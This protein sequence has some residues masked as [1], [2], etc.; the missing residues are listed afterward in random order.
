MRVLMTGGGTAGHVNPAIAIANTIKK[1]VEGANIAF[2]CSNQP[3]DI[4]NDLVVR[5]GYG[6]PYRINICGM[7]SIYDPRN[8]K[9]LYLLMKSRGEAKRIIKSYKP[10][11]IIGTG[12]FASYPLLKAGA[13]MGIPTLVHES[14]AKAGK[15]VER[16]AGHVDCIMTNFEP[17]GKLLATGKA[18][19]VGNPFVVEP[20]TAN[21]KFTSEMSVLI[22]GGSR[23][24][25]TLNSAVAKMLSQL[26]DKYPGVHFYHASGKRGHG[27]AT[28]EYRE[29]GIDKK[30]NVE[31]VDYIY[32]MGE[33]L[34]RATVIISRAGAMTLS[35]IA[36]CG[37]AAILVPSPFVANN[38]QYENA[39][40]M[41]D[42]DA[43][44]MV[45]E[46]DFAS[47]A[48]ERE[49]DELLSSAEKR[50]RI[51]NNARSFAFPDAN[52]RIF[53]EIIKTVESKKA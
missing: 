53:K 36:L 48:L 30:T 44:V 47:G 32:D 22:F 25:E 27:A 50:K 21:D 20:V 10:D 11:V 9:T 26:A 38:H 52:E 6:E 42:K 4:A 46:K 43:C 12:G 3:N 16:L 5:A 23:G 17:S 39:K 51:E 2:V 28:A 7:Y 29:R 35:E 24:A 15:A 45:E 31:L 1:K 34:P 18:I 8:L 41:L 40:T 19:R 37:K 13:D 49:L 33:R 14:N